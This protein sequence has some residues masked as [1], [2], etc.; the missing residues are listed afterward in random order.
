MILASMKEQLPL[1]GTYFLPSTAGDPEAVDKVMRQGPVAMIHML[2]VNGR[3]AVDPTIMAAGFVFNL[4]SIVL[5]AI[6]LRSVL[7]A[8]PTYSDRV[9]FVALAGFIAAFFIDG[10]EV[11]WWLMPLDW[12]LYQAVYN[13]L[14]WLIAGLILAK[15]VQPAGASSGQK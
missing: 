9:K 4:V 2:A 15:F 8:L 13:I 1:N 11:A 7:S 14:F 6:L 5:I 3:P 12:K 10:G